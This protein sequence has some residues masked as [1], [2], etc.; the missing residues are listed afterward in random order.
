MTDYRLVFE[1]LGVIGLVIAV[2]AEID[3]S[4]HRR[5]HDRRQKARREGDPQ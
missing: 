5:D 2:I 4:R 1:I 3:I